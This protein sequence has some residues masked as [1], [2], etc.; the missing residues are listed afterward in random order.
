MKKIFKNKKKN[1]H[2][3]KKKKKLFPSSYLPEKK[4]TDIQLWEKAA[5]TPRKIYRFPQGP[6]GYSTIRTKRLAYQLSPPFAEDIL[7]KVYIP[8]SNPLEKSFFSS[9]TTSV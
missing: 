1:I 8:I 4:L 5:T 3:Y 6:Y 9:L 7:R 2:F